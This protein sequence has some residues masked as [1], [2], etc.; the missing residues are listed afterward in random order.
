MISTL[1]RGLLVLL[2]ALPLMA[3]AAGSAH[4][5]V[6]DT[7][8]KM[9]ADLTANNEQYKQDPS[10]FYDSLNTIVGPV[11]DAEGISRSIMTV[12]YSRKAT[13]AQIARE[14]EAVG[15]WSTMEPYVM[16]LTS[17]A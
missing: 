13:P 2:A 4:E 11:V 9:L 7:T 10:K 16:A 6:Q 5:L 12:K 17:D 3:N 8:S 15:V 1:R 14:A